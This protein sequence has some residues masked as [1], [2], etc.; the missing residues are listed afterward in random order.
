MLAMLIDDA[1]PR[2]DFVERHFIDISATPA[3][4][5]SALHEADLARPWSIRLLMGLRA[6]PSMLLSRR[7]PSV[8]KVTIR[9]LQQLGFKLLAENRTHETLLGIVGEFWRLSGNVS[10]FDPAQFATAGEGKK[11]RAVWNF[12]LTPGDATTRLSTETRIACPDARTRRR[13][14]LYWSLV[15]PFSGWIRIA[16]LREIRRTALRGVA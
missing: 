11:A 16:M 13:F 1:L 10:E 12:V 15:R 4:V 14:R 8:R 9:A 7:A 5:W 6:L 3:A 2:Y